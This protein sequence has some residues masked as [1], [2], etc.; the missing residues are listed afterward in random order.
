MS[1]MTAADYLMIAD[2]AELSLSNAEVSPYHDA[3]DRSK[4]SVTVSDG[5]DGLIAVRIVFSGLLSKVPRKSNGAVIHRRKDGKP[6]VSTDPK[7]TAQCRAM[8]SLYRAGVADLGYVPRFRQE[9]VH[10]QVWLANRAGIWD[11]HNTPKAIGDFLQEVKLVDNDTNAQIWA[12]KKD[13]IVTE[14]ESTTE[15]MVVKWDYGCTKIAA[16][17]DHIMGLFRGKR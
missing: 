4:C 9:K 17:N 7:V 8:A 1:R 5:D 10:V 12:M 2:E 16:F 13:Y 11:S 3:L 14:R 15:I 6:F